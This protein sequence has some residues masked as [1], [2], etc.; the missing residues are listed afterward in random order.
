MA[1]DIGE[2]TA[3]GKTYN[4][5]M[6]TDKGRGLLR[7]IREQSLQKGN[8][9]IAQWIDNHIGMVPPQET[10]V[11]KAEPLTSVKEDLTVWQTEDT[12]KHVIGLADSCLEKL[13]ELVRLTNKQ[14]EL[15]EKVVAFKGAELYKEK[16]ITDEREWDEEDTPQ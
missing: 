2:Y 6:K 4:E 3:K 11:G 16:T 10:Q 12:A 7:W 1:K 15:L 13:T 14:L 8:V 5:L 9:D